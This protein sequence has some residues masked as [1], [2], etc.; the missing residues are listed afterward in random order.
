DAFP[1][2]ATSSVE[3]LLRRENCKER[4][5]VADDHVF[6]GFDAYKQVIDSG[7]DVVILAEPPHFR[8]R[9]LAYAVEKGKHCFVEKPIAVD[10]PGVRSAVATCQRAAQQVRLIFARLCN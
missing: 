1:D 3:K 10:A 2:F 8:P 5:Q 9:S 4:V 6:V 7:V